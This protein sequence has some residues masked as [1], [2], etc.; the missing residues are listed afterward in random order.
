MSTKG[1]WKGGYSDSIYMGDPANPKDRQWSS[2]SPGYDTPGDVANDQP[3]PTA[4]IYMV[5]DFQG[6][7]GQGAN[8]S[9]MRPIGSA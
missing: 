6:Q 9:T 7:S 1:Y 8:Q 5:P 2:T 3:G 4:D